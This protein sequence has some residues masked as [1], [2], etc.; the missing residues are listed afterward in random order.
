METV[1]DIDKMQAINK[2]NYIDGMRGGVPIALGYLAVSFTL[3]IKAKEIGISAFQAA[4]MSFTNSTSAGEFAAMVAIGVGT[5]YTEMAVMQA[6]INMRYLLMSCVLSQKLDEKFSSIH[7]FIMGFGITDE[8]FGISAAR[9]GDLNPYYTYGAMSLA[10]PAWTIGTFL[11]VVVG[12]ILPANIVSALGI[13]LY[14]MFIAIIIPPARENKI[15]AGVVLVSMLASYAFSKINLL[16]KISEG[17]RVIIL[18][19]II[20]GVCAALFPVKEDEADEQ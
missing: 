2:K 15:I 9:Q 17:M 1:G 13:A 3:G 20:A 18:T 14:G 6:I 11:G 5:T 19:V 16:S 7:R 4:L 12:N 8:I 10:I